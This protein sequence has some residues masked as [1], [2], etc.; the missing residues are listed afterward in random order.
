MVG[1]R[2]ALDDLDDK[3][4]EMRSK[5]MSQHRSQ[6]IILSEKHQIV[7]GDILA[8]ME[9]DPHHRISRHWIYGNVGDR[10]AGQDLKPAE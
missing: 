3:A 10:C 4:T 1:G 5:Y 7:V 9:A 2:E 6:Q 8:E